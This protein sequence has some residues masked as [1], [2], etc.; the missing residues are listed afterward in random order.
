MKLLASAIALSL[1][2]LP[3]LAQ[4]APANIRPTRDVAVTYSIA[5]PGS[6]QPQEIRMAW[7]VSEQK[8]RVEPQ[9][10]P[11]W[12][13]LDRRAGSATMVMDAQRM[14]MH[15]PSQAATAMTQDAPEGATFVRRGTGRVAGQPCTEW[16]VTTPQGQSVS[17]LTE[18][19]VLLRSVT[20]LPQNRGTGRM[21][22]TA[23]SYA[24]QDAARFRVPADYRPMQAPGTPAPAR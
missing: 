9:G 4:N 14:I 20:N 22:A 11:G 15:L 19:G 10:S 5:S 17:C 23:V 3:A 12:M 1:V 16:Q 7:L 2:A 24:A 21:E 8:V 18:D 6:S 13:L